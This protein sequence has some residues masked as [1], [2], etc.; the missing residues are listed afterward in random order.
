MSLWDSALGGANDVLGLYAQIEKMKLDRGIAQS[1]QQLAEW[2]AQAP[3]LSLQLQAQQDA[4]TAS[5]E[6]NK[7]LLIGAGILV[8]GV[9]AYAAVK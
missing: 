7:L 2:N 5:L 3:A 4:Q 1:N 8:L 6:N 9:I